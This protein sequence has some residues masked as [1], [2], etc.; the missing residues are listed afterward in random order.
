MWRFYDFAGSEILL[1]GKVW[2]GHI[3]VDHPEV[4]LSNIFEVLVDP[5]VV[6]VSLYDGRRVLYYGRAWSN[7][8]GKRRLF[9]VVVTKCKDGTWISTAHVRSNTSCGEILYLSLA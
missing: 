5:S 7:L 1:S 9:R 4:S 3:R 2:E 8:K 6:C